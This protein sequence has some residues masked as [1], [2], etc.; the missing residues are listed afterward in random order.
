MAPFMIVTR[1]CHLSHV[2]CHTEDYLT[3]GK[4]NFHIERH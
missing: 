4:K 2:T 3:G 1:T